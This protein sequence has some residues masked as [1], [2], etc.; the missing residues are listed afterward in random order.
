MVALLPTLRLYGAYAAAVLA[1]VIGIVSWR[2]SGSVL[3]HTTWVR[4]TV[5]VRSIMRDVDATEADLEIAVRDALLTDEPADRARV[6]ASIAATEVAIDNVAR[7]LLDNPMQIA[8][9]AAYREVFA[10]RVALLRDVTA[11]AA[12][13]R[14]A[15]IDRLEGAASGATLDAT[16]R[17]F[18]SLRAEE[19]RLLGIRAQRVIDGVTAAGWL[20]LIGGVV[21]SLVLVTL[22]RGIAR[23][24]RDR[25]ELL[26]TVRDQAGRL[27]TKSKRLEVQARELSTQAVQLAAAH[28][29]V[30]GSIA[31][32]EERGRELVEL[33]RTLQRSNADLD[34]FAYVASHD[35][36]APLRGIANLATWIEE[37]LGA[38]VPAEIADK[39]RLMR[40]R[41]A[42]LDAL[43]DG[44]LVYARAGRAEAPATWTDVDVYDLVTAVVDLLSPPASAAVHL[45]TP[46]PTLRT[47]RAPLE[48]LWMN[49]LGNAFKYATAGRSTDSPARIEVGMHRGAPDGPDADAWIGFVRDDGPGIDPRH[50]A[51]VFELFQTLSPRDRVE[52]TGIGLAV[53]AKL[54]AARG[55]RTWVESTPG[56]GATFY[57][58]W[59]ALAAT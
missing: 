15:A 58:T 28:Q 54:V 43:I 3:H 39:L 17:L 40:G 57:F 46:L 7:R 50:H 19:T 2:Q 13:D 51:K 52:A 49:L 53:V 47:E 48:Q 34:Q 9:L 31:V 56:A 27:A 23:H 44:I 14:P 5:D 8:Q 24:G 22:L 37:D 11:L 4:H 45:I 16:T 12:H 32:A 33:N 6:E 20:A 42:R 21:V 1:L 25:E 55:G 26:S 10:R 41:V 38:T 29:E 35:L 36:K 59:P 30:T 18:A